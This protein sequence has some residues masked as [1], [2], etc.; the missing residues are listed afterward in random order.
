MRKEEQFAYDRLASFLPGISNLEVG[1]NPPDFYISTSG[2]KY[3]VEVTRLMPSAIGSENKLRNVTGE[4]EQVFGIVKGVAKEFEQRVPNSFF[5][6][7][8]ISGPLQESRSFRSD[9][10]KFVKYVLDTP[11]AGRPNLLQK[12]LG[13][14]S[15][16]AAITAPPEGA[17]S[18]I[19]CGVFN[20]ASPRNRL[21]VVQS[22]VEERI[23]T[24]QEKMSVIPWRGQKWLVLVNCIPFVDCEVVEMAYQG[25]RAEH[26]FARVFYV[27]MNGYTRELGGTT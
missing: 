3:A 14:V 15:V 17:D 5:I 1:E 24:K 27:G 25:T 22:L 4:N 11:E 10:R 2:T 21:N 18:F 8:F 20:G 16:S 7:M 9:L 23:K 26:E 6:G 12:E 19:G 13:G